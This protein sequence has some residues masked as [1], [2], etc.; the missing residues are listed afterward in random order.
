M[1]KLLVILLLSSLALNYVLLSSDSKLGKQLRPKESATPEN[2]LTEL[3]QHAADVKDTQRKQEGS[4]RTKTPA[5]IKSDEF[6]RLNNLF[7]DE[8]YLDLELALRDFLNQN[9]FHEEALLLEAQLIMR[10]ETLN[11]ALTHY[12]ELLDRS[13]SSSNKDKVQSIIDQQTT[14]VIQQLTGDGAWEILA[15]FLEPLLQIDPLNQNYILSLARAYGM[16]EQNSLMENVL[17]SMRFD[18]P[19]AQRLRSQIAQRLE[20]RNTSAQ[21]SQTAADNSQD[22]NWQ[23]DSF[24]Q[25]P[26]AVARLSNN[27]Q[28]ITRV[29]LA[30]QTTVMLLDTGA[31]TTAVKASVI[32]RIDNDDKDFIGYFNVQ[33]AGGSIRAPLYRL[34]Y[35]Q[36]GESQFNQVS[37]LALPDDAMTK[38]DG[39]LG[40][41]ILKA[42]EMTF[43]QSQQL[44]RLVKK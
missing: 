42:Y 30:E 2:V 7:N 40:M 32:N 4:L 12:Y 28:L 22:K 27:N 44:M 25:P 34:S 10:T 15:T 11:Y 31:S 5:G 19:R 20:S 8:N 29:V 23:G 13:L 38:F 21:E 16:Q 18:H 6:N 26:D 43:D 41:N 35:L 1:N 9:P 39:L 3:T 33:T 37:V 36:I 17:A 24:S 14:K